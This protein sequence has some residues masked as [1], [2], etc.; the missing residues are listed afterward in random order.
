MGVT[1]Y[2]SKSTQSCGWQAFLR[3]VDDQVIDSF[4]LVGIVVLRAAKHEVADIPSFVARD[5]S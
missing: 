3:N 4:L 1:P 5:S 2:Q